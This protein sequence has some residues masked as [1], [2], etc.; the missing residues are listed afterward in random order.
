M[1]LHLLLRRLTQTF[2][3]TTR[4]TS[5]TCRLGRLVAPLESP[6]RGLNPTYGLCLPTQHAASLADAW[7]SLCVDCRKFFGDDASDFTELSPIQTRIFASS[8]RGSGFDDAALRAYAE[9]P[10]LVFSDPRYL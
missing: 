5:P 2:P 10:P 6:G 4:R 7:I 9:Q 1:L 8:C 3:R